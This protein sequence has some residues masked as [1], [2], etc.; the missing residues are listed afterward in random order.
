MGK[1]ESM[2][3]SEIERLAKR[4]IRKVSVPL[5]RNVR[6]LKIVA[7]QLRKT[8]LSLER[9]MSQKQKELA[10]QPI[11]LGASPEEMK[12]SRFSPRL[13]KTLRK[14][15][16]VSQKGLATLTG[17]SIGAVQMW[18]AGKFTPKA[19]KKGALATLRKLGRT[20]VK[21]LLARKTSGDG[22]G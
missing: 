9:F 11:Q 5:K 18:E 19:E 2:I 21:R 8:V 4:E 1:L 7:S 6:S 15:L 22:K 13:V 10:K 20:E 16:G 14:K 17:V 12:K 3:K